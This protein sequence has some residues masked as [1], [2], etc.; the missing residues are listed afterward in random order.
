MNIFELA[1]EK[2]QISKENYLKLAEKTCHIG[3]KNICNML[4]KEEDKHYKIVEQMSRQI[5]PQIVQ[6]PVIKNF[7]AIF[8]KMRDS[9]EHFNI[10]I[11]ELELY[12]KARS[13]EK[14]AKEFY[15]QQAHEVED[16]SQKEIFNKLA[17]EEQKHY[18]L[19]D[20]ICDFLLQPKYYLENAEFN[21]IQDYVGGVF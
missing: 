19:V 17:I 1:M 5:V 4:A 10:D 15:Q 9:G 6:T 8:E 14:Q 21:H 3:L 11:S 2:E 7:K 20:N 18:I 12:Q 13:I 16:Q